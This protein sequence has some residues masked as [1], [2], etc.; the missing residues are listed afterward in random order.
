MTGAVNP[1]VGTRVNSTTWF[2]GIF[3][4]EDLD[5]IKHGIESGSWIE[6]GLGGFAASLDAITFVTNPIAAAGSWLAAWV[7]EHLRPL[8]EALECLAGDADQIAAYARTWANVAQ[9]LQSAGDNLRAAIDRDTVDWTGAAGDAYRDHMERLLAAQQA[10]QKTADV[11][12]TLVKCAGLLVAFVRQRVRDMVAMAVGQVVQDV[13]EEAASVGA[14]TP[15]VLVQISIAVTDWGG[16]ISLKLRSLVNS[17]RNLFPIIRRLETL[18]EAFEAAIKE[19][20]RV[21]SEPSHVGPPRPVRPRR[22]TDEEVDEIVRGIVE[23]DTP[24][25]GTGGLP[26]NA[27]KAIRGEQGMGFYYSDEKGWAF[28]DGPSGSQSGHLWNKGG[29]DGFAYTTQG[30]FELHILDNKAWTTKETVDSSSALTTTLLDNL[31]GKLA[32]ARD[33]ALDGSPRITEVRKALSDTVNALEHGKPLPSDVSLV[34]TNSGGISTGITQDL[35]NQGIVF[36]DIQ[37]PPKVPVPPV[38]PSP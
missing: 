29:P 1:L 22:F 23:A 6:D 4:L 2:S 15:V 38:A 17:L 36:R 27:Q 13:I 21:H 7:I 14:A 24:Q 10:L 20:R 28:L 18:M 30:P 34:V 32:E 3:P 25:P 9:A 33:P 8:S 11:M 12:S 31:K 19:L 16:R 26:L 35:R 37:T 5:T